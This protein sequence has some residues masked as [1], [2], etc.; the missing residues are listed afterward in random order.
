MGSVA[1]GV[2][3]V[4]D[5]IPIRGIVVWNS[6]AF[7]VYDEPAAL[8][9][10]INFE[11]AAPEE[12]L[13]RLD[14]FVDITAIGKMHVPAFGV[15]EVCQHHVLEPDMLLLDL[16]SH[17]HQRGRRFRVF[18]GA[19]ACAAGPNAGQPCSPFGPDPG[20]P[21][22]DLCAGAPCTSVQPP[23]AGD[24][25]GDLAVGIDE[26]VTGVGLA[27]AG[28]AADACPRFDA[29]ADGAVSITELVAAVGAALAPALRDPE[30]SL[31]YR[32]LTY[33]DPLVLSLDPPLALGGRW[34][35]ATE[36]TLTY[37]ALYDNGF[38][39]PNTVKRRSRLPSNAVPCTPTHCAEGRVG[40]PCT[41]ATQRT[42]DQSCDSGGGEADGWCD[43]CPVG[44]GVT[45]DDE[46]FVLIGSQVTR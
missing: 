31:L 45:T 41:G 17:V 35:T 25:D 37:C 28:G 21:L 29:D 6:H 34:S 15:D 42:R 24:C 32:S 30:D 27:L 20:L 10:W 19:F 43:A 11:F 23:A 8:D 18:E 7:N 4:Y 38:S 40:E 5:E 16:A 12:Q 1:T 14:R 46:M 13:R 3:G 2:D 26:L 39:D 36:R 44:F 33:A 22:A 9:A